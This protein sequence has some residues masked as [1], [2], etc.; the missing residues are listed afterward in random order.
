MAFPAV[1]TRLAKAAKKTYRGSALIQVLP[2]ELGIGG[3]MSFIE[4]LAFGY[5]KIRVDCAAL[6]CAIGSIP[7]EQ[8]GTGSFSI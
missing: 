1:S 8:L 3:R 7:F 4:R 6:R 5:S 2:I